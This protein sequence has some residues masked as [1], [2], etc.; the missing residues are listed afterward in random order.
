MLREM[1]QSVFLEVCENDS[2]KEAGDVPPFSEMIVLGKEIR[3]DKRVL[4]DVIAGHLT[5][6]S[7]C[8][9]G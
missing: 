5:P 2:R 7:S 3:R 1:S 9:R 4:F 8:C 6:R